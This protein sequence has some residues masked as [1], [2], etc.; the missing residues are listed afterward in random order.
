[1]LTFYFSTNLDRTIVLQA[2]VSGGEDFIYKYVFPVSI[3]AA[4]FDKG[5]QPPDRVSDGLFLAISSPYGIR[6][7]TERTGAVCATS[8]PVRSLHVP[9]VIIARCP[10]HVTRLPARLCV[11]IMYL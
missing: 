8:T 2:R 5:R 1:M 10:R 11:Y 4:S 9:A 6:A 3:A 7:K